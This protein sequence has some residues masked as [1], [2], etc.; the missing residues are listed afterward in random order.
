VKDRPAIVSVADRVVVAEFDA[1]LNPTDPLPLPFAPLVIVIQV[2]GDV[3]VH[4]QP[5]AAV[6]DTVPVPPPATTD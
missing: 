6:T 2:T 5:A 3:A 4:P 1:A